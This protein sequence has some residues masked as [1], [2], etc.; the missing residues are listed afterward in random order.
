VVRVI[1][2]KALRDFGKVHPDATP[3]LSNWFKTT[4][5]ARWKNLAELRNDF[6]GADQVG[7]RTVFNIAGNKYRLVAR[8]NYRSRR[9]FIVHIL[10]HEK[11]EKGEWK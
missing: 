8:V 7:R 11:Y 3:S 2:R 1:G 4:R 6:G 10:K 5:K 9:T